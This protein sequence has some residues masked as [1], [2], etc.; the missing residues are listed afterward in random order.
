M[1]A[2]DLF[3]QDLINAAQVLRADGAVGQILFSNGTYQVEVRDREGVCWPFLQLDC[4]GK[5][6]DGFCSCAFEGR[7]CAHLIAAYFAIFNQNALPLHVRFQDSLWWRLGWILFCRHGNHPP[8]LQIDPQTGKMSYEIEAV[9]GKK[10]LFSLSYEKALHIPFRDIFTPSTHTEETSIKFSNLEEDELKLWRAGRPSHALQ[11]ELSSFSDFA[12]W[13]MLEAEKSQPTLSFEGE[14]EGLPTAILVL[15]AKAKMRLVLSTVNWPDLILPLS[16]VDSPLKVWEIG[17]AHLDTIIYDEKKKKFFLQHQKRQKDFSARDAV[18]VGNFTY[19]KGQGFV[20]L[21]ADPLLQ[22]S[23]VESADIALFLSRHREI[24]K[25]YLQNVPLYEMRHRM[26]YAPAFDQF[27]NLHLS[28]YVLEKGDLQ[29]ANSQVYGDWAYLENKGF[30][31]ISSDLEETIILKKDLSHFIQK[32]REWL[33]QFPSFRLHTV[34][35]EAG[36]EYRTDMDMN[37]TFFRANKL[38]GSKEVVDLGDWVYIKGKGFYRTATNQAGF[39][40]AGMQVPR[41]EIVDFINCYEEELECIPR[42]FSPSSPIE[43]AGLIVK[44]EEGK[45]QIRPHFVLFSQ[46][47]EAEVYFLKNY[48]YVEKE[49][50][51]PFP[52][53]ALFPE[54]YVEPVAIDTEMVPYF[55]SVELPKLMPFIFQ[56]DNRL[57]ERETILQ[58]T[59]IKEL[60]SLFELS[61]VYSSSLGQENAITFYKEIGKKSTYC[62]TSAGFYFLKDPRFDWLKQLKPDQIKEGRIQLSFLEWIRLSS[63]ETI[64]MSSALDDK[65]ISLLTN[66]KANATTLPS[67]GLKDTLRCYQQKGLQWLWFLFNHSLSG[68]LCDEMGLGKTHQAMALIQAVLALN[69]KARILSLCPTSVI[70]H[71]Q[72]L[73]ARFLPEINSLTYYG[74]CR[75]KESLHEPFE[76]IITSYGIFRND[77]KAFERLCFD[78]VIFDEIQVAKNPASRT[79]KALLKIKAKMRL[80]LTGTPIENSLLDLK[81]LFDIALPNYLPDAA[82]YKDT[83]ITPIE[84][85]RDEKRRLLLNRLIHPFILRRKKTDVLLELPSKIEEVALCDL[86]KAQALL[87]QT[88]LSSQNQQILTEGLENGSR[89][90]VHVFSLLNHLKQICNHPALYLKTPKEYR[91]HTSGK[92]ELFVDVLKEVIASGQKVVIFSQY[93]KMMD[94]ISYFLKSQGIVFTQVRGS[95]KNRKEAIHRFQTDPKCCVF[96]GSLR[97]VGVGIDLTAASVVIHYDRWWNPAKENQATDRVHRFGQS[98]GVQV[99]KLMTRNTIEEKIHRLIEKKKGLLEDVIGYDDKNQIKK[100]TKDELMTLITDQDKFVK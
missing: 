2:F 46:Y 22:Q 85:Y 54:K 20:S 6:L 100:F 35:F 68:L 62:V 71:W 73:V 13:M 40:K 79:H 7:Y 59:A 60:D 74:A 86:T 49:G 38:E 4:L 50:F 65:A 21:D 9:Q 42:F 61:F 83:F 33:N 36:L 56:L 5:L 55:I 47:R 39:I 48:T 18:P 45:I 16:K 91:S 69:P 15:F 51:A 75:L 66:L 43:K 8:F 3:P 28:P 94:I 70:Y 53:C 52:K 88:V 10:S 99:F 97:A 19:Y 76:L 1:D 37:L 90:Y 57:E 89:F 27:W 58:V 26:Q 25:Q 77:S 44:A 92:W 78:V 30:Y 95:T 84:K 29:Q 96:I 98:R 31:C 67:F 12:K 80:G 64:E 63:Y 14:T 32:R 82:K 72:D 81:A 11:Y 17:S 41:E 23:V 87:Y 93:L 34:P 24:L